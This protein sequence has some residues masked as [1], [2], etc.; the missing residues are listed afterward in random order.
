MTTYLGSIFAALVG[1]Y[2]LLMI[3]TVYLASLQTELLA[4]VHE[5]EAAIGQLEARYYIAVGELHATH[6]AT[7]GLFPPK[8]KHYAREATAPVLTRVDR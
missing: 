2:L 5:K 6:P 1:T 4:Q 8:V 3:G 7:L